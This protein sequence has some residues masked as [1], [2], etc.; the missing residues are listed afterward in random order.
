MR[1]SPP[2]PLPPPLRRSPS[3]PRRMAA[4]PT[5]S[6]AWR[7]PHTAL[8][9]PTSGTRSGL[10]RQTAPGAPLARPGQAAAQAATPRA[11]ATAKRVKARLAAAA[12]RR[13]LRLAPPQAPATAPLPTAASWGGGGGGGGSERARAGALKRLRRARMPLSAPR[14]RPLFSSRVRLLGLANRNPRGTAALPPVAA[15]P[16]RG[17]PAAAHPRR[18]PVA[19]GGCGAPRRRARSHRHG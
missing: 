6:L 12:S 18:A 4:L 17:A 15:L 19:H 1:P 2:P 7:P 11:G 13:P 9:P 10:S 16:K 8:V 5:G 3:P 14:R